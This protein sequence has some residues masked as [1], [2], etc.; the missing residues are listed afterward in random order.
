MVAL[1]FIDLDDFKR[2]NDRY[3]HQQGDDLLKRVGARL[4]ENLRETDTVARYASDEFIVVLSNMHCQ[5]DVERVRA[6]LI[7]ALRQ[8]FQV[9]G[10]DIVLDASIG[11]ALSPRDGVDCD[12]LLSCADAAMYRCKDKP[13]RATVT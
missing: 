10:Q 11:C 6:K 1:L 2:I 5:A 7:S 4:A 9:A 8:P 12:R 3:G 13:D